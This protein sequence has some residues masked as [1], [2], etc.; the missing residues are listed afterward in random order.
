MKKIFPWLVIFLICSLTAE[1]QALAQCE[2][3]VSLSPS[4]TEIIYELKLE[5]SLVGVSDFDSFP[6]EVKKLPHVGA[7]LSPSLEA[8]VRL[9]PKVIFLVSEQ[10]EISQKFSSLGISTQSVDHR[11]IQGILKSI[12]D[13]GETCRVSEGAK[14]LRVRLEYEIQRTITQNTKRDTKVL[15]IV[16][17]DYAS[18]NLKDVYLSGTDGY[19]NQLVSYAGGTNVVTEKTLGLKG[20]SI[21][22]L[23]RLNP[24]VIIEIV[25]PEIKFTEEELKRPW[26]GFK[27]VPAVKNNKLYFLR[28]DWAYT[29]GPRFPLL[30]NRL[31]EILR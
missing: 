19:Y 28:E 23:I 15:F 20:L 5:N 9:K 12:T 8:V 30:L 14:S 4:I 10:Q 16:G 22:A 13:I 21:E 11:S 25:P 17:R 3:I 7:A 18:T 31:V 26:L 24:E 29:P 6:E 27:D 1:P 2:R